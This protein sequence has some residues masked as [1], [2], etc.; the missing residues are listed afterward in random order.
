[1][2]DQKVLTVVQKHGIWVE[3]LGDSLTRSL[4]CVVAKKVVNLDGNSFLL[5]WKKGCGCLTLL[6]GGRVLIRRVQMA[7]KGRKGRKGR[8]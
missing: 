4:S 6:R 3:A 8:K 1:M 5:H 2:Q 7:R